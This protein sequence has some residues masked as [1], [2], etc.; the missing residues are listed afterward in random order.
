MLRKIII[1]INIF[2]FASQAMALNI[3]DYN[4][5]GTDLSF[6]ENAQ[7]SSSNPIGAPNF[8]K[9][10]YCLVGSAIHS[11][12]E[13]SDALY[14]G[15]YYVFFYKNEK[16]SD[17]VA[18]FTSVRDQNIKSRMVTEVTTQRG[19]ELISFDSISPIETG[20][21]PGLREYVQSPVGQAVMGGI[22]Q[23]FVMAFQYSQTTQAIRNS[24]VAQFA[25]SGL[26]QMQIQIRIQKI[27]TEA[28]NSL[29]QGA[30]E[31]ILKTESQFQIPPANSFRF[32]ESLL[33]NYI[34]DSQNS[35]VDGR[36]DRF[37]KNQD[38]LATGLNYDFKYITNNP[39]FDADGFSVFFAHPNS[40]NIGVANLKKSFN[41]L[42]LVPLSVESTT[43]VLQRRWIQAQKM[44]HIAGLI[45]MAQGQQQEA[46]NDFAIS[47]ELVKLSM[48]I[49]SASRL[50]RGTSGRVE[51][52]KNADFKR[53]YFNSGMQRVAL[54]SALDSILNDK[55][56]FLELSDEAQERLKLFSVVSDR[57]KASFPEIYQNWDAFVKASNKLMAQA[58]LELSAGNIEMALLLGEMSLN[59]LDV[60]SYFTPVGTAEALVN[61]INGVNIRTGQSLTEEEVVLN[62]LQIIPAKWLLGAGDMSV[63]TLR[64][65]V[66]N[67][68][69]KTA[70]IIA[71]NAERLERI[72]K[73]IP[74][75]LA[76][77]KEKLS[78]AIEEIQRLTP[79]GQDWTLKAER[80]LK[81]FAGLKHFSVESLYEVIK[82]RSVL[83][84]IRNGYNAEVK[85]I[86]AYVASAR[87]AQETWEN[88]ARQAHSMRRNIGEKYK[89]MTPPSLRREIYSRNFIEYKDELGP[90][91]DSLVQKGVVKGKNIEEIYETI[92]TKAKE[93]NSNL[94]SLLE[95]LEKELL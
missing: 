74:A 94:N 62:A 14:P 9:D 26:H 87:A 45:N 50:E 22:A 43:N 78:R 20:T 77:N 71:A 91:F 32:D 15:L 30:M 10:G 37:L 72:A 83:I 35:Y 66:E 64:K 6:P 1:F 51:L 55:G 70:Q 58:Q 95:L 61:L 54:K 53:H 18:Y 31:A 38:V 68:D 56:S 59:A 57:L 90:S 69:A 46:E 28:A 47:A 41:A 4:R 93:T 33:K 82:H 76:A 34:K 8:S 21:F 5:F 44:F 39:F 84:E 52:Q 2:I 29:A 75:S 17:K 85:A 12:G 86:D 36:Y 80:I 81:S 7:C 24:E 92:I 88:I 63:G 13:E 11:V 49:T 42:S 27:A 48:N 25:A 40:K 67:F 89:N 3:G 79:A 16:N 19:T 23:G 65:V 73:Y 60:M